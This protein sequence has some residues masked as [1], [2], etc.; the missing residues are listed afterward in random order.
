MVAVPN[1]PVNLQRAADLRNLG[2]ISSRQQAGRPELNVIKNLGGIKIVPLKSA[3]Y[4]Q[5]MGAGHC[6]RL[7]V[8]SI[9]DRDPRIDL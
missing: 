9:Q 7:Q 1:D 3:Q 5:S 8:A 2:L 4:R 6:R